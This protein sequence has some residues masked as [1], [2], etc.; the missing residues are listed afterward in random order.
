MKIDGKKVLSEEDIWEVLM[1]V[2]S[3]EIVE[4]SA[5]RQKQLIRTIK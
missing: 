5:Y 1:R 4:L 3:G 2:E